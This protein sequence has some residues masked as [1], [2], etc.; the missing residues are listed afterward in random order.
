MNFQG[1]TILFEFTQLQKVLKNT[2]TLQP[3]K[4]V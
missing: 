3:V 4:E 2:D 1:R